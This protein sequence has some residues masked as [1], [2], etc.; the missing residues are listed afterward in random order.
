MD[1]NNLDINILYILGE[2]SR[3]YNNRGPF[4]LDVIYREFTDIP[5][6]NIVTAIMKL[7]NEKKIRIDNDGTKISLSKNGIEEIKT[8]QKYSEGLYINTKIAR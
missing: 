1:F 7:E 2:L 8:I 6:E 4:K 3:F 5:N